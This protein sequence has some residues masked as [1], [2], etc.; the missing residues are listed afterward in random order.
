MFLKGPCQQTKQ[1]V[2]WVNVCENDTSSKGLTAIYIYIYIYIF[3]YIF[4]P[5]QTQQLQIK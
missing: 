3:I 1:P 5:P 2:E 4:K